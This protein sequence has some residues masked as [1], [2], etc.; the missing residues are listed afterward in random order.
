M[1]YYLDGKQV[2]AKQLQY[3]IDYVLYTNIV[4]VE[5]SE[6]KIYFVQQEESA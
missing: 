6:N 3:I 5:I 4:L 2:S 1:E